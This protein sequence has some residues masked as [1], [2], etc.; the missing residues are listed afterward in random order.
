MEKKGGQM[1]LVI[2]LRTL[3]ALVRYQHFKMEGNHLLQDKLLQGD[4]MSK[5]DLK[6]Q[7]LTVPIASS[8]RDLLCFRWHDKL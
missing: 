2:N 3:N 6:D 8:Y 4:Y 1:C 7:Y 5:I